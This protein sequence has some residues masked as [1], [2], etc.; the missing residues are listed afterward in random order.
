[1]ARRASL[2]QDGLVALGGEKLAKLIIDEAQHNAP[3]KRIVTAALAGIKGPTAVAAIVDR[4][5]AGLERARGTIDWTKRKALVAELKATVPTITDQLGGA[6]PVAAAERLL[7]LLR[8]AEQVF[9]RVDDPSGS[10]RAILANAADAIP[11][12]IARMAGGDRMCL[13]ERVSHEGALRRV[14][15]SSDTGKINGRQRVVGSAM[16]WTGTRVPDNAAE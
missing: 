6:D 1:M 11:A 8:A 16:G 7:R 9:E 2:T 15:Q 12:L 5:L 14:C 10:V 3:S 4:R 13:V